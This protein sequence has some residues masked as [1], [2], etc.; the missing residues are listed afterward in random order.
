MKA[1]SIS[2]ILQALSYSLSHCTSEVQSFNIFS[3]P[4]LAGANCLAP[5]SSWYFLLS[6]LPHGFY[7]RLTDLQNPSSTSALSLLFSGQHYK[8]FRLLDDTQFI[9]TVSW[10]QTS[11]TTAINCLV[12]PFPQHSHYFVIATLQIVL[13]CSSMSQQSSSLTCS[14]SLQA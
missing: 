13:H 7:V 12:S 11:D 10:L 6:N 9:G 8:L 1:S 4:S 2:L 14:I 5:Q 3:S